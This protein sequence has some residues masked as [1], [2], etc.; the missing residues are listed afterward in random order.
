MTKHSA[1][2]QLLHYNPTKIPFDPI[3]FKCNKTNK[4]TKYCLTIKLINSPSGI[5]IY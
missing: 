5:Y 1:Y 3:D 2:M 4:I